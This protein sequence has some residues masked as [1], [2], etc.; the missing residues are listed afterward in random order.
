MA[1][2]EVSAPELADTAVACQSAEAESRRQEVIHLRNAEGK[3]ANQQARDQAR[4]EADQP[5]EQAL[6]EVETAD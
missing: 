6:A 3:E 2:V 1:R 4:A 5:R